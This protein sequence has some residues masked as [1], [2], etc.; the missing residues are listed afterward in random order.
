MLCLAGPRARRRRA[1]AE[2]GAAGRQRRLERRAA[3]PLARAAP[4]AA[5]RV[6][7]QHSTFAIPLLSHLLAARTTARGL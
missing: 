6:R 3:A 5:P 4:R 2:D 7:H 1:A